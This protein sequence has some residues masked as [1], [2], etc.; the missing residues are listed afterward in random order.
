MTSKEYVFICEFSMLIRK[1][2][3][4]QTKDKNNW[5]LF[6]SNFDRFLMNS[7]IYAYTFMHILKLLYACVWMW[8]RVCICVYMSLVVCVLHS[9]GQYLLSCSSV[10]ANFPIGS[11]KYSFIFYHLPWFTLP[12]LL[13][14]GPKYNE[15][16]IYSKYAHIL[17]KYEVFYV[18]ISF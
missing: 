7:S 18:Y 13:T 2:I 15:F 14:T 8:A 9:D 1:K 4:T 6:L 11:C 10:F 16:D 3:R 12:F 17:L 5:K